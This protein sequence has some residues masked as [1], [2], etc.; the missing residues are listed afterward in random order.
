M[1]I[2]QVKIANFRSYSSE[3]C[4]SLN[5][6]TAFVGKNDV[7][8]STVLEALDVF[9]NEGKGIVKLD[10][11]DI[12]KRCASEGNQDIRI[13]IVFNNIPSNI[14][15]DDS[16][17]TTLLDEYLLTSD[18]KLELIKVYTN[19]GKEKVFVKAYHPTNPKCNELLHKKQNDLRKIIEDN[20]IDGSDRT[21]NASMRKAIWN[22]YIDDLSLQEVEIDLTKE[23]AKNI[24]TQLKNYLPLYSLFQSDR[25]NSD[26]DDEIQD[27]MKLAVQEILRDGDILTAL[28]DVAMKVNNKLKE[29]ADGTCEKLREMNPEIASTLKPVIP[30]SE[31]LKWLDV[32]KNVS[33]SGDEDIP[34]NKRGSGVKRLVLLNFFRAEADRRKNNRPVH[35]VIYAIEEPETSQHPNHQKKLIDALIALSKANHTQIILTTHSPSLVKMLDFEHLKLVQSKGGSKEIVNVEKHKL[36]YPSLNEI[37]FIAFDESNEEYHNELYGFIE[38]KSW[39]REYKEGKP[40]INYNRD[41]NGQTI[42]E[43]KILSE[44]IRHQIHHPENKQNTKYDHLQLLQSIQDMRTFIESKKSNDNIPHRRSV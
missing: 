29:V 42:P 10:K 38:H 13:S 2:D 32:F 25:K 8:K 12:N 33:I 24:W 41:H 31:S 15:I 39:M 5:D 43:Q 16:N 14:I 30:S 23:D 20:S 6:L 7:G 11:D 4:V 17:K 19:P 1:R 36:P 26:G 37:N 9:F 21:K 35:D 34:L 40:L 27:P 18:Q 44:Y 22:H 3:V 28:N